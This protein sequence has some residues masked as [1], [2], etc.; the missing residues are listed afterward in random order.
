MGEGQLDGGAGPC[1]RAPVLDSIVASAVAGGGAGVVAGVAWGGIGGRIAMRVVM[2]T[3]STSVRGVTSDDGFE[4]GVLS[5]ATV[6]LVVFGAVLGGLA[7]VCVGL[8]RTALVGSTVVV[9]SGIGVAVGLGAGGA[10]VHTGGVDFRF[11]EPL[12]LTVGLFVVLP[13]AW[14]ASVVALTAWLLVPGRVLQQTPWRNTN[15]G[16]GAVAWLVLG[17]IAVL[18][19][20]DLMSDVRHLVR[21]H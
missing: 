1:G 21:F 10:I 17:V 11:L 3:S 2:L 18:G 7:G 12:W 20:W 15:R 6:F 16:A 8:L 19:G 14:G 13:G 9:A 5:G 4:I